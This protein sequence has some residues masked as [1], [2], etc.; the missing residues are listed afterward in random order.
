MS[1]AAEGHG[2]SA[3]SRVAG[4][5]DKR[6]RGAV[7][8]ISSM[9]VAEDRGYVVLLDMGIRHLYL[10]TRWS[11]DAQYIKQSRLRFAFSQ[12]YLEDPFVKHTRRKVD[13]VKKKLAWP[14]SRNGNL[15]RSSII[16]CE[17][18]RERPIR[19][20]AASRTVLGFVEKDNP[21]QR[22]RIQNRS[23]TIGLLREIEAS[24]FI[25]RSINARSCVTEPPMKKLCLAYPPVL[26]YFR[27]AHAVA[28]DKIR[29]VS[30]VSA[31]HGAMWVRRAKGCS[32]ARASKR[33]HLHR[34]R[35]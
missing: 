23:S 4:Q 7:R 6:H 34:P 22:A 13:I 19:R 14:G 26:A 10:C 29:V 17:I 32:Q 30:S 2:S 18:L 1:P 28:Q 3:S 15:E 12:G 9:F 35:C 25:K 8:T 21:R 11:D 31:L 5:L 16:D 20:C 27:T 24:G 33:N